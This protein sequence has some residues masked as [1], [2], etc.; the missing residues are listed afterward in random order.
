M[1]EERELYQKDFV[2]IAINITNISSILNV[3][4]EDEMILFDIMIG[5]HLKSLS[6]QCVIYQSHSSEY[7]LMCKDQKTAEINSRALREWMPRIL[8]FNDQNVSVTYGFYMVSFADASFREGDFYR[9]IAGLRRLARN[10]TDEH[11]V[12][13]YEGGIKEKLQQE[14]QGIQRLNEVLETEKGSFDLEFT[15]IYSTIHGKVEELEAEG[16]LCLEDGHQVREQE[17]W[18]L[19]DEKGNSKD[20]ALR[21]WE[22][23]INYATEQ[24][25]FEHGIRFLHINVAPIQI[26][27][28][29][30]IDQL[31]KILE[32]KEILPQQIVVE[33]FVDQSVPEDILQENICY[34]HQRGF[35]MLL[36]Q[37][38]VN[39]CNLKNI[40]AMPFDQAKINVHMTKRLIKDK[41][42][43]LQHLVYMLRQQG[44]KIYADGVDRLERKNELLEM[45]ID[46]IQGIHLA[47][48]LSED[49]WMSWSGQKGGTD[50]E[51]NAL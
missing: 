5:K 22:E 43:E 17:L 19:S 45:G 29:G 20:M 28:K 42:D 1:V 51:A 24:K 3:C 40:L 2:C 37:F 18:R 16:L 33:V 27:S 15:P 12:I 21:L 8:R 50:H 10:T 41:Q 48:G 46:G 23:V 4:T 9:I 38:G 36:D 14:L 49:Q 31:C 34:M 25:V 35:H 39:I 6:K 26:S 32:D 11:T 44:W 7:I 30:M 13:R 47:S